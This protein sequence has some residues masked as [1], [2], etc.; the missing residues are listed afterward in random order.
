L[1]WPATAGRSYDILTTTNVGAAFQTSASVTP[2]NSAG[3][4]TDTNPAAPRRVYRVR[5]SN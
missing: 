3:Q 5:T 2:S 1:A 4:W